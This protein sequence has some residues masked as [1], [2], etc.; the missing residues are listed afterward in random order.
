M[1]AAQTSRPDLL[2]ALRPEAAGAPSSGIVGVFNYGRNREGLI[3]LWVGEG[4]LPTPDFIT[5][6]ATRS[7]AAGETYYTYQRGLPELRRALAAYHERT[8]GLPSDPERFFVTGSG[9]QAIQ[10]A[11]TMVAGAGD[12]VIVPTPAWPNSA[13]AVGVR[14]ARPVEVAMA[15]GPDGWHLDFDRLAAAIGPRTRAL[16]INSPS[17]PIGWVA[18]RED[19]A[20]LLDLA[21]RHGLWIV[22]DEVYGRFV[23]DGGAV[24]PSF[25]DV[26]DPS[27]RILYVNTFSKN[28][29]MTGW[30]VGW[31][32]ADPSLGA[33][34]E[35][36][37]Q[38]STSGV[39]AFM[40]RAATVALEEGDAFLAAQLERAAESRRIVLDGLGRSNR[41]R[42]QAPAGAF[43]LFF[44]VEGETD[45][46]RLAYRIIDEAGV[47]LAPGTAFGAG[48][49]AFFRLCYARSPAQIA[50]ATRRLLNWL[51][52]R[53]DG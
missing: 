30:R 41:I 34:I 50:E 25:R 12:E 13:A 19:L 29:A 24:A 3:P 5:A 27:D 10:I 53:A 43:Y 6:A 14:G 9:M 23:Y 39:A 31:I 44:A 38:Y 8:Y 37:I 16:T 2:S 4:D 32:E 28:W 26:A 17:N 21:R 11:V 42:F 40:Q 18:S 48:G 33:V 15:F 22:A 20:R 7:L 52:N 46:G 36:L 49:G 45:S 35:N 1:T 47:G 51:E